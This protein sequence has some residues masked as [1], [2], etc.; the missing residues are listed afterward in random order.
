MFLHKVG[1][2]CLYVVHDDK[3]RQLSGVGVNLVETLLLNACPNQ[4]ERIT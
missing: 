2:N 4:C 1:G 3:C